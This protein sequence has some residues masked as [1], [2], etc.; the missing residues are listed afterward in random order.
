MKILFSEKCLEYWYP[1]H[2]ESPTRIHDTFELLK[3]KG[4]EFVEPKP[5]PERE[6]LL[7]HDR[8]F[9]EEIKSGNFSYIDSPALPGIYDYARLSAGAAINAMEISLKNEKTFSLMRPPGHHSGKN[10]LALGSMSLGFCYFNNIAI[11]CKKALKFVKKIAIIDFDCHHGNGTQDIFLGYPNVLFISLHKYPFY[12]GTGEK[13]EK[14]CLNYPLNNETIEKEYLETFKQ[15]LGEVKEFNPNLIAVSAGFDAH[16]DD[17]VTFNGLNLVYGSFR[18]IGELI[19]KLEIPSF[20]VL[21]GGYGKTLPG[22]VYNF[23][24]GYSD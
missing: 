12:P 19:K 3:E 24:V 13:S 11:A 6:L 14:N 4:F 5:C 16:K 15:A 9:V 21:E 17:D 8:K 23:L 7:V 1:G 10:G 22:S 2:S 20:A 18:R